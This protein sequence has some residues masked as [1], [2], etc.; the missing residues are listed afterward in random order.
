MCCFIFAS[1]G[2]G[3][4]LGSA[5]VEKIKTTY[6]YLLVLS[7]CVAPFFA[8]GETPM[9]FY[10]TLLALSHLQKYSDSILLFQNDVVAKLLVKKSSASYSKYSV[11]SAR[12]SMTDINRYIAS[13]LC[14]L[15]LPQKM[16]VIHRGI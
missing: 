2:T 13:C 10:N 7:I 15:M 8:T 14:G 16:Y 5:M 6:P 12:H 9:Q 3:S 11:N 4:G 1:G